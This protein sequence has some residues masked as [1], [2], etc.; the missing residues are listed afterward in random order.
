M[1]N[2]SCDYNN[3][4]HPAVLDAFIRTNDEIS[5]TYGNDKWS[6]SAKE[7]I[8]EACGNRDAEVYFLVGGTQTNATVI[9]SLMNS[10]QGVIA[11]ESGHINTHEAGAIERT[12]HKVIALPASEGGKLSVTTLENY[13]DAFFSDSNYEH[14]VIPGMVYITY[15]TELGALYTKDEISA[16]YDV[17]RARNLVLYGDGARLGYGMTADGA[18]I[19]LPWLS[20]HCDVFYI[21]GTKVGAICGEAVVFT[22]GNAPK[23]FFSYTKQQGAL[24]AKGRLAGVQFD[25]LFT[26]GLYFKIARQANLM[27]YRM[28]DIFISKGYRIAYESPTNQQFIL[29]PDSRMEYF[30]DNIIFDEWGH[31]GAGNTICRFV[32]SWATTEADLQA[33]AGII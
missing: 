13:L 28:R 30:R 15:P 22:H 21:G 16:I 33:L 20:R 9:H 11:V 3:G 31:D 25:A 14:S 5:L 18:D 17:C 4:M 6:V 26:D 1:I 10:F 27:A 12:G 2:L 7:R 24:L 32:T 29:I 8:R 19:D 23:Y